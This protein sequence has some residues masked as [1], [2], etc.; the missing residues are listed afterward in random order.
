MSHFHAVV[1]TDHREARVFHFSADAAEKLTLR[2]HHTRR[3]DHADER[4]LHD[5]ATAI[6]DAGE[7]LVT[8]PGGAKTELVKH[9][10]RHDPHL[11]ARVAG[12]ESSD[13]PSDAQIVAHARHYFRVADR[14]TPQK[15]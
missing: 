9:I 7:I 15:V 4:F 2:A 11:L 1:W 6:A 13:H 8:G 5:V 14:A 3:A 12:V 10:A